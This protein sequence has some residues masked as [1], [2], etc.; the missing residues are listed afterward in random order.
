M[1]NSSALLMAVMVAI[2]QPGIS[3]HPA[4]S[5]E[6][7]SIVRAGMRSLSNVQLFFQ[8]MAYLLCF[9]NDSVSHKTLTVGPLT[10][11]TMWP[12]LLGPTLLLEGTFTR[13]CQA[14]SHLNSLEAWSTSLLPT[15]GKVTVMQ[16]SSMASTS[17]LVLLF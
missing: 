4:A 8:L 7:H 2:L 15:L 14:N 16:R 17:P 12:T 3:S 6:M 13:R 5:V 10:M 1:L 11:P 9:L